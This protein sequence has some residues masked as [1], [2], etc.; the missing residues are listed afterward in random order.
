MM[1]NFTQPM[2]ASYQ[3]SQNILA[4]ILAAHKQMSDQQMNA[5][6]MQNSPS[7]TGQAQRQPGT[8]AGSMDDLSGLSKLLGYN[9]NTMFGYNLGGSGVG[10]SHQI[11]SGISALSALTGGSSASPA[12]PA[13]GANG[14]M[15]NILSS[16]MAL[17]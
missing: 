4:Q 8:F 1:Q 11:P 17:F 10:S 12:S 6:Q 7:P 16:L 3:P 14:Q 5:P 15:G 2:G 9:G 13:S